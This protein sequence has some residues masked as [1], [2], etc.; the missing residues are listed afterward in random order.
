MKLPDIWN[1]EELRRQ[2]G[3]A[4]RCFV[5]KRLREGS[6]PYNEAFQ[7]AQGMVTDLFDATDDLS[8]F[9]PRV[10]QQNPALIN[11]AR[12]LAG[13]PLS[14]DD[15]N[16]LSGG[17]V[18]ERQTISETLA[19]DAVRALKHFLDPFRFPWLA[20]GGDPTKT[21]RQ[22]A[23]LWTAGLWAVEM[24]RTERRNESSTSQERAV[25]RLLLDVGLQ[26]GQ[27]LREIQSLDSLPRGSFVGETILGG[28]KADLCVRI[29]DGRLLA[30][31]CKVSNSVINSVKRLNRETCGKAERWRTQYG[32]QV[33]T[34][35]VLAGVFKVSNLE[36]AQKA[37]VFIF[38]E[39]DLQPLRAFLCE[40][41]DPEK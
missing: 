34:A 24:C 28:A 14:Q 3:L 41:C 35:C 1:E 8:D 13:P 22:N 6:R 9:S 36:D 33:V 29:Q 23:I 40:V 27:R 38:W 19:R 18:A 39:H 12:Y 25:A 15:L 37:G 11:A 2:A 26:R 30:I 4:L 20:T 5:R 16:T 31:E 10:L 7:K 17:P 32:Q 21:D